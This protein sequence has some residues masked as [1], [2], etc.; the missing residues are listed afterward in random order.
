MQTAGVV[1]SADVRD[2][3]LGWFGGSQTKVIEG[4][5][6]PY[7]VSTCYRAITGRPVG[8]DVRS[9]FHSRWYG[10]STRSFTDEDLVEALQVA[11]KAFEEKRG[12]RVH[13]DD[14]K[15]ELGLMLRQEEQ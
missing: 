12:K 15:R 2:G 8:D 11:L 10:M 6:P 14:F 1:V 4:L 3:L 13:I 5:R 7:S 9:Y